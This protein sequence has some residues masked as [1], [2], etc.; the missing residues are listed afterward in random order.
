MNKTPSASDRQTL[1]YE[2]PLSERVRTYLRIEHLFTL[3]QPTELVTPTNYGRYFSALFAILDLCERSDVR[4]DLM[5]DLE[6]R[7]QQLAFWASHPEVDSPALEAT[8]SQL[9]KSLSALQQASR[10]GS[11]LKQERLLGSIRQRFAMSGGTCNFDLPQLHYW[12]YQDE[13]QRQLDMARWW[14]EL[15]ELAAALDL[16]LHMLR[17]HVPFAEVTASQGLLQEN[18]ETLALLRL[19]V[20]KDIPAFPVV[21]GH[22]QRFSVRFMSADPAQGRASYEQDVTFYLARCPICQ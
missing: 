20:P 15:A 6:K 3:M 21:S 14:G 18:T 12:L 10:I 7:K 4:T 17:E 2:Y 5:K 9:Q 16:E 1:D 13:G 11:Q 19:Q 8:R 22:K